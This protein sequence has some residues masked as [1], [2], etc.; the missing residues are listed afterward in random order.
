MTHW[1]ETLV[2]CKMGL[3]RREHC[4]IQNVGLLIMTFQAPLKERLGLGE[5]CPYPSNDV[6]LVRSVMIIESRQPA[7]NF[8]RPAP[9]PP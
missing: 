3:A 4:L 8:K 1:S 9:G 2:H 6:M 7:M 5:L